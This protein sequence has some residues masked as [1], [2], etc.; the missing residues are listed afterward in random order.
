MK[1][2]VDQLTAEQR[3]RMN[4]TEVIAA[5]REERAAIDEVIAVFE[6]LASS[7]PKRKGRPPKWLSETRKERKS[8]K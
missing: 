8:K 4:L 5:L 6:R 7:Q 3:A 2:E 1:K